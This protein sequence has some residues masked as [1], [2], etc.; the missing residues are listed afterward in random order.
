MVVAE[1]QW[2]G[3]DERQRLHEW[4]FKAIELTPKNRYS[5]PNRTADKRQRLRHIGLIT[6][7]LNIRQIRGKPSAYL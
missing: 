4:V 3:L 1:D 5:T 6:G 7:Q 2:E